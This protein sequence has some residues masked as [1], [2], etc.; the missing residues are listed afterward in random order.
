MSTPLNCLPSGH[1][2]G[3]V[4][5]GPLHD[6]RESLRRQGSL[7]NTKIF[8]AD[9]CRELS[10]PGM[11]M[12]WWMVTIEHRDDYPLET[13]DLRDLVLSCGLSDSLIAEAPMK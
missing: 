6:Q 2:V 9:D 3:L 1:E 8:K 13:A 10:R 7:E 4:D 11:K 12:G 5:R